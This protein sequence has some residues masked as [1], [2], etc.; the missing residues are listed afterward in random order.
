MTAA[1]SCP[2]GPHPSGA[3]PGRDPPPDALE[4]CPPHIHT[5][6]APGGPSHQRLTGDPGSRPAPSRSPGTRH[7]RERQRV[8][9]L[10]PPH[11]DTPQAGRLWLWGASCQRAPWDR[12]EPADHLLT[13]RHSRQRHS[14][15]RRCG[16]G[17]CRTGVMNVRE[18]EQ[19]LLSPWDPPHGTWGQA[20]P[21]FRAMLRRDPPL[22][23]R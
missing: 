23:Q 2:P 21:F 5:P 3:A 12:D 9:A 7:C 22:T 15:G 8:S 16:L 4:I 13:M 1:M 17:S 6:P 10:Q 14:S 20:P 11:Q 18:R 19:Q